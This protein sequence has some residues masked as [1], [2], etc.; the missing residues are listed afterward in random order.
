MYNSTSGVAEKLATDLHNDSKVRNIPL[1]T[2]PIESFNFDAFNHFKNDYPVAIIVDGRC[3]ELEKFIASCQKDESKVRAY[4][5]PF[6]SNLS[7][8]VYS[9]DLEESK[10]L[11]EELSRIG[12]NIMYAQKPVDN[13]LTWKEN[14]FA[15][16]SSK[17]YK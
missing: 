9:V 6:W 1:Q 15:N 16:L 8:A 2:N 5:R 12:A 3:Q 17:K 13:F 4:S 7:F 10:A 14:L 11:S